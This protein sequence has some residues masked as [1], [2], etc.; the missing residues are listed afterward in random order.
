MRCPSCRAPGVE[1][2]GRINLHGHGVRARCLAGPPVLGAE[3]GTI[4][5]LLRRYKCQR[6]GAVLTVGPRGILRGYVYSAMALGLALLLWGVLH[7]QEVKV[8]RALGVHRIRGASRPERWQALRRWTKAA[9]KGQLWRTIQVS[10]R[11]QVRELAERVARILC[12]RAGPA[13][14]DVERIWSASAH[15]R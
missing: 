12:A 7:E 5:I 2:G 14:T 6:C 13:A 9:A 4:D 8:Q 3:P 10:L 1:L 11:G 15:A